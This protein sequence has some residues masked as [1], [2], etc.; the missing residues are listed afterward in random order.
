[1]LPTNTATDQLV[2]QVKHHFAELADA[3]RET[4][5]ASGVNAAF[6]VIQNEVD[7]VTAARIGEALIQMLRDRGDA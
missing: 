4:G 3:S 2:D 5:F 1:M 6:E 7:I